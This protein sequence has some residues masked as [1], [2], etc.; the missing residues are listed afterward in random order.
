MTLNQT[1]N[2]KKRYYLNFKNEFLELDVL[3]EFKF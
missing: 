1:T 2:F 3:K